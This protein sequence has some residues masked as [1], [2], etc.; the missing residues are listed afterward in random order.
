[1]DAIKEKYLNLYVD[2]LSDEE[3]KS[4]FGIAR[5]DF[6]KN[7]LKAIKQIRFKALAQLNKAK[8]DTIL[9]SLK[10]R[11]VAAIGQSI[12]LQELLV[13]RYPAV[14]FRN[15]DKLSEADIKQLSEDMELINLIEE[16]EDAEQSTGESR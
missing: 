14:Q 10:E 8:A 11:L 9:A 4:E 12:S 5:E 2:S 7:E 6:I 15:L 16:V 13:Q 3:Q 1:M